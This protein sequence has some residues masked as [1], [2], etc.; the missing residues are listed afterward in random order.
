MYMVLMLMAFPCTQQHYYHYDCINNYLVILKLPET[1][2]NTLNRISFIAGKYMG[3]RYNIMRINF[4]ICTQV[5]TCTRA[6]SL[7]VISVF[8]NRNEWQC[9]TLIH[10][11]IYIYICY[12]KIWAVSVITGQRNKFKKGCLQ[13]LIKSVDIKHLLIANDNNVLKRNILVIY[14]RTGSSTRIFISE[15]GSPALVAWYSAIR[16]I[17]TA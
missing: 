11:H 5:C 16:Y 13:H 12:T 4:F 6:S 7:N 9:M 15:L 8:L 3:I 1:A 2:M 14:Y 17:D 10:I